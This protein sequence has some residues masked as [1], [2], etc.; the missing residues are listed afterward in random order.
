MKIPILTTSFQ[1]IKNPVTGLAFAMVLFSIHS[2]ATVP[3]TNAQS[4][5]NRLKNS[6]KQNGSED[7]ELNL[8]AGLTKAELSAEKHIWAVL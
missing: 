4:Q 7:E 8:P 6:E 2:C 1:A 3:T 5:G